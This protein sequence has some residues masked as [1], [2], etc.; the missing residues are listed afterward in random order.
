[1]I[2]PVAGNGGGLR[3]FNEA[4]LRTRDYSLPCRKAGFFTRSPGDCQLVLTR[5]NNRRLPAPEAR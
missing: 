4:F 2:D 3:G 5:P 1:M